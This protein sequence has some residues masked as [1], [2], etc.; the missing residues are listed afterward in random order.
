M[1]TSAEIRQDFLDF[2]KSKQH[3]IVSSAPVVPLDDPTLMFTNAGMNQ[4]K[5]VFLGTG[6]R[7]Y[8]RVADTQKCI[9]V[10]GKHN[11]LEEVGHDT[12]HH[13]LFEM[14][15]NWSFGDYFKRD[16]I[17]WAWELLV[18][19]WKVPADKLYA[20]VFGGD[21][22]E[23]LPVDEEA[24]SFWV[25]LTS[26]PKERVLRFGKKDN[27]W[28]MGET[29]PC[30]LCTEI[31]LDRGPEA[32]DRK[33]VKGHKCAVNGGCARFI[34][35]WNLVFIQFNRTDDG[36]LYPLP[37]KHVD[38]GMGFERIVAVLQGH[39]SNYDTDIFTPIFDKLSEVVGKKYGKDHHIDIA[40][41]V[42]ADH[43]R[44]LCCAFAD[45]ALPS[46][47]GRGYVLRRLLR[48]AARYGRQRLEMTE[49]FIYKLAGTVAEIFVNIFPEINER[50][51]H[52]ELLIKSEE[53]A[54]G[55]TIDKG[56]TLFSDLVKKLKKNKVLA[57]TEAFDLYSTYGFPKD[58]IEL[59]CREEGLALDEKGWQEAEE[60][61]RK[62]SEGKH[63]F[64]FDLGELEGQGATEFLGYDRSA[65]SQK[66]KAKILKL[67]GTDRLVLDKTPFYAESGGQVGD[68]GVIRAK[69]FT[70][71]VQDTQ[72][73]GD[74]YVHMG[75]LREGD[76][77]KLPK[78]VEAEI[79]YDRRRAI[80]ANH[81][82]THLLHWALK[83]LFGKTANQAGSLVAPDKLRF[84]V[85]IPRRI[86]P[87]EIHQME[88]M[89]NEK[90]CEN[91]SLNTEITE[92]EKAKEKG[93]MALFGEK[94]EDM[95][96]MVNIGE[97]SLELCGGTH[98]GSTG[99][100]GPFVITSES[101]L[102]TGVRRIEAITRLNATR[103]MQR[104]REQLSRLSQALSAP[105]EEVV[106]RVEKLTQEI[107]ELKKKSQKAAEAGGVDQA[108]ELLEKA[109]KKGKVHIIAAEIPNGSPRDLQL[110][111][112]HL[113]SA[114]RP[115]AG[116]LAGTIDGKVHLLSLVSK[117]LISK[118]F[119]A[120]QLLKGIA[121][122]VGGK[123]GGRPD[124]AQGG[125]TLADKVPQAL[126][127]AEKLIESAF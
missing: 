6:K 113:V 65:A 3:R 63:S 41:R 36:S 127:E 67:I 123:G 33:G 90:I 1:K 27:F 91:T 34:E 47:G 8:T 20:T 56:I 66:V 61:H 4:F 83:K 40:F 105:A 104:T 60:E 121:D 124:R 114:N 48:R 15:G 32:C 81:T 64:D 45:G 119:D 30:G 72:K 35:I 39:I 70:F 43:L 97:Y 18:D 9:R 85:T 49:P 58:L 87:E 89:I 2:F 17:A 71:V 53:E 5:D 93:A 68:Q 102:Q 44:A 55:R 22:K 51:E 50:K 125:G 126:K 110:I 74:I 82:A 111:A 118:K 94:Y 122:I 38:T 42:I 26:L 88:E 29:G 100:I 75:E 14:L 28:E 106:S 11:D 77:T 80:M 62:K 86:T 120:S 79:N 57:G 78:T 24:E 95:V 73:Y 59:M 107:K 69:S 112:D 23:G 108:R 84:D 25:E 115:L 76:L 54:F 99:E 37:A 12:Y 21:E 31:H 109:S 96:R 52:L 103:Y 7:D 19:I 101:S 16:A 10:S 92:L 98:C 116:L 46:N 13:T 117:D